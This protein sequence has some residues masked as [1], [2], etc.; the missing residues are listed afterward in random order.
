MRKFIPAAAFLVLVAALLSLGFQC[1][2]TEMTSAR[3]YIQRSDWDNAIRSLE[4]EVAKNPKNEEAWFLLGQVRAQ[5]NDFAGMV[6]AFSR[7]LEIGPVH[8]KEI[9]ETKYGYWA[10]N[11][12]MGV[13]YF[14]RGKDTVEY[15]DKAIAA[16]ETAIMI[17]PDSA[18]SYRNIAFCYLS[19]GETMKALPPLEKAFSITSDP[20]TARYIGEIYYDAGLRHK[21]RFESLENKLEVRILMTP[22]EV[23]AVLGEPTS[24]TPISE[25]DKRRKSTKE[26]WVYDSYKLTLN[27]DAG[28]LRSWEEAGRKEEKE[29]KV[30][31]RSYAERDSAQA[32]FEKAIPILEKA[33]SLDQQNPDLLGILSNVY[34]AAD[35]ADIAMDTFRRG[36]EADPKNKFFRY[37]YGVLLLKSND[38]EKAINQFR[39]AVEI[40]ST[41]EGALYNLGVA[42]VN[43][44]V[45]IR[46]QAQEPAKVEA[47]YKEKF[48][49]S[50][51]Y[52]ERMTRL[53][54]QDADSWELLGKVY[55]NLGM[56]KDAT[57]AFE[58]ADKLRNQK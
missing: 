50:L 53:K 2:S 48:K 51:P 16:F 54:P 46:E 1:S 29:P 55:A 12:N 33:L 42:Y 23:R 13:D 10:R 22:Q 7:A 56:S 9:Q 3:L 19:K 6:E 43:W 21:D 28:Q 18:A 32:Y 20:A 38:Y 27:F 57:E 30:Y 8:A 41:Y 31:Y 37:N 24:I 52:L 17:L 40:D 36:V 25:A 49:Q 45:Q 47:E 34:I 39:A 11:L 15:Y 35:K 44:G 4:Q 14:N 5:K 26:K 58:K